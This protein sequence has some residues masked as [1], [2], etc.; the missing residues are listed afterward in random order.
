M[1]SDFSEIDGME[2][3]IHYWVPSIAPCGICFVDSDRYPGWN[4][5]LLIGSLSFKFISRIIMDG[6]E[7]TGEEKLLQSIG[8]VRDIKMGP[9][10]YI[11]FSVEG[12]GKMGTIYRIDPIGES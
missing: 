2:S 6:D 12:Y 4:G 8:R 7:I 1:L 10:G 9:D 11:Y 5:D 3:P